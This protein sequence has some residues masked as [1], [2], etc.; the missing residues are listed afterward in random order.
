MLSLRLALVLNN[1][2]PVLT[3]SDQNKITL[4]VWGRIYETFDGN[5]SGLVDGLQ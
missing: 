3:G 2:W 4:I 1:G 5:A